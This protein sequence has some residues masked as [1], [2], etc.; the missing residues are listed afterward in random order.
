MCAYLKDYFLA[1][2]MLEPEYMKIQYKFFPE[3]IRIAYNL[4]SK[5]D[6]NGFIHIKIKKG[7]YG[8][9]QAA[10]LAYTKLVKKLKPFGCF[11]CPYTTCLWV[12]K[13]KKTKFCLCVNDFGIQY[14][15]P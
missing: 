10:I 3:E 1:T 13:T 5:V 4:D 15:S 11:P 14:H 8:L 2:F 9:N 6:K 12:H 7:M